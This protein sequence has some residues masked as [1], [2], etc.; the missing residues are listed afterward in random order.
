[1]SLGGSA[2]RSSFPRFVAD[3]GPSRRKPRALQYARYRCARDGRERP[4]LRRLLDRARPGVAGTWLT[5]STSTD[6]GTR[7]SACS[8]RNASAFCKRLTSSRRLLDSPGSEVPQRGHGTT[9]S[10]ATDHRAEADRV[11][12]CA[13]SDRAASAIGTVALILLAAGVALCAERDRAPPATRT[14]AFAV[15]PAR[16]ALS[17]RRQADRPDAARRGRIAS[18]PWAPG[19]RRTVRFLIGDVMRSLPSAAPGWGCS[20]GAQARQRAP[21]CAPRR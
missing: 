2:L 21:R 7:S 1:M 20:C 18:A 6:A 16:G 19:A 4:G 13:G 3:A 11:T 10:T 17:Q 12:H 15:S 14:N 5:A 8:R 9:L